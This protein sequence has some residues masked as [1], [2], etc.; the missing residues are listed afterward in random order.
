M[1]V[2]FY[3]YK[4]IDRVEGN[5][6]NCKLNL[7][8]LS[9]TRLAATLPSC[10]ECA[11]SQSGALDRA[12]AIDPLLGAQGLS[13][14]L[15]ARERRLCSPLELG[16]RSLMCSIASPMHLLT[17]TKC[18]MPKIAF[19]CSNFWN[20]FLFFKMPRKHKKQKTKVKLQKIARLRN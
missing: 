7:R 20:C 6:R 9:K 8:A 5:P 4:P 16:V 13:Q 18:W 3:F 11:T 19:L 2:I 17:L 14:L 12:P 1:C 10:T 15:L